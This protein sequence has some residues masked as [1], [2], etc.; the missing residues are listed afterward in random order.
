MT[1]NS[2]EDSA[3]LEI[4]L[5]QPPFGEGKPFNEDASHHA[6]KRNDGNEL[7]L[8]PTK[9][10]RT[11]SPTSLSLN[12]VTAAGN[13]KTAMDEDNYALRFSIP[14]FATHHDIQEFVNMSMPSEGNVTKVELA[15]TKT[16]MTKWPSS[17]LIYSDCFDVVTA[18]AT[19]LETKSF[20]QVQCSPTIISP[21]DH[22]NVV[23]VPWNDAIEGLSSS[24]IVRF[25][26]SNCPPILHDQLALLLESTPVPTAIMSKYMA[27]KTNGKAECS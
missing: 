17:V 8:T 9:K 6:M 23:V 12:E 22:D 27:L 11:D 5:S 24:E 26:K 10:R 20:Y 7:E 19:H 15:T 16:S 13:G 4:L 3:S 21:T 25:V 14:P 2:D 1:T 18:L